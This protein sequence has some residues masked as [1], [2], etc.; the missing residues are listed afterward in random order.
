MKDCGLLWFPWSWGHCRGLAPSDQ[1][2][3]SDLHELHRGK[4]VKKKLTIP[5]VMVVPTYQ[6][7]EGIS[8]SAVLC[9]MH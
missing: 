9:H 5:V 1:N 8:L 3:Q 4:G 6:G 2:N 7:E